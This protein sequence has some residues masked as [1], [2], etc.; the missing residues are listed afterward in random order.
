[1]YVYIN[2]QLCLLYDLL[3]CLS[4]VS[5]ICLGK[6]PTKICKFMVFDHNWGGGGVS[7]NHTLIAKLHCFLKHYIHLQ[8]YS[9]CSCT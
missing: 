1:M 5:I 6:G 8:V 9:I 4:L 3:C 7:P 2:F